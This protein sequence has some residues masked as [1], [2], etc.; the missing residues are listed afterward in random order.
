MRI[1]VTCPPMLG[2][3]DEFRPVFA[4]KNIELDAPVV[5]QT[6]SEDALCDILPGVDGWIIGDDPASARVLEA[7]A[8]GRVKAIV[9]WGRPGPGDI[10]Y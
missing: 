9:E 5:V 8:A 3:I 1:L 7:G 6:M 10:L 4:Q 2:M